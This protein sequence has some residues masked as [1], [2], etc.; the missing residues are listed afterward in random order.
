MKNPFSDIVMAIP[1]IV[2]SLVE[3]QNDGLLCPGSVKWGEFRG[4]YT[5]AGRRVI[6]HCEEVDMRRHRLSKKR[7]EGVSDMV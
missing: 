1:N 2:I 7:N 6:S 3:G 4:V 5:G